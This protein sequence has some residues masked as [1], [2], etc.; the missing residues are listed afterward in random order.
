[1]GDGI[2]ILRHCSVC[3]IFHN[4]VVTVVTELVYNVDSRYMHVGFRYL[5]YFCSSVVNMCQE[6]TVSEQ[7]VFIRILQLDMSIALC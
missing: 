6:I 5:I 7:F 4:V 3:G 1:M 2:W